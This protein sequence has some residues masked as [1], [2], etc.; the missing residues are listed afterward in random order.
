MPIIRFGLA[1]I[2]WCWFMPA[3]AIEFE[4]LDRQDQLQSSAQWLG[5]RTFV[6][7]WKSDCP[8]CQQELSEI[9]AFAQ[10][11]PDAHLILVSVDRWQESL[12]NLSV[13]PE[14]VVLLRSTNGEVLLRRFGNK[15]SA[16]PY[17][18]L[19]SPQ[20]EIK[21]KH[22][23]MLTLSQLQSWLAMPLGE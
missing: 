20:H 19:M 4:L 6:F 9:A 23:G 16:V 8:A 18:V 3:R 14:S 1:L 17:S 2:V 22:F 12:S 13:L 21:Q 15:T 11:K 5:K 7:V 10:Q